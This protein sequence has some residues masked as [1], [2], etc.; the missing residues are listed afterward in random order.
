MASLE[1]NGFII[2]QGASWEQPLVY[3][4]GT[5]ASGINL[6]GMTA[7]ANIAINYGEDPVLRLTTENSGIIFGTGL[8]ELSLILNSGETSSL[9]PGEYVYNVGVNDSGFIDYIVGGKLTVK[10][11][12]W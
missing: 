6:S 5:P 2:D 7:F 8:G 1:Y 12:V 4:S 3:K 10:A 9:C 11:G